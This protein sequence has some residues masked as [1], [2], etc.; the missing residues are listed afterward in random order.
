MNTAGPLCPAVFF[1]AAVAR[2][3][4][5][6]GEMDC[7]DEPGNDDG[8]R[9]VGEAKRWGWGAEESLRAWH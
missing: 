2:V 8:E 7:P 5:W 4:G 6:G 1:V 9:L 3:R